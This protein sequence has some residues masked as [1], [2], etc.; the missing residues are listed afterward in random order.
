MTDA[1][2][3]SAKSGELWDRLIAVRRKMADDERMAETREELRRLDSQVEAQRQ[4][5]AVF[6]RWLEAK[7]R[8]ETA[9]ILAEAFAE[10]RK[11]SLWQRI[12]N[13][14]RRSND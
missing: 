8:Y 7:A 12:R 3:I 14:F 13:F 11:P 9:L 10:R 4:I 1:K 6:G 5:A 2:H